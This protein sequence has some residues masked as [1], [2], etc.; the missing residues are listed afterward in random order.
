MRAKEY[1]VLERAVGEGVDA[2]WARA[3][4]HDEDP[5]PELIRQAIGDAVMNAIGEVFEFE[6]DATE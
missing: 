3:H 2:G 5:A 1:E 4:K 6:D